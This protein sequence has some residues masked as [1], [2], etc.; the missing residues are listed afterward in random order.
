MSNITVDDVHRAMKNEIMIAT[1][2]GSRQ[3]KWKTIQFNPR[4]SVY[5]IKLYDEH[6]VTSS[7]FDEVFDAIEKYNS[8]EL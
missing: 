2:F 4:R 5:I 6:S 8:Y 1:H 3:K 7:S